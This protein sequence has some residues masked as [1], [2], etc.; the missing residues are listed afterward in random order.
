V[1]AGVFLYFFPGLTEKEITREWLRGSPIAEPMRDIWERNEGFRLRNITVVNNGPSGSGIIF[2]AVNDPE[3]SQ[4]PIGYYKDHQRWTD[5][6]SYWL[7]IDD[8]FPPTAVSLE[9]R[10]VVP[11]IDT[12]LAAG[13]V[14]CLPIIRQPDKDTRAANVCC[15]PSVQTSTAMKV[16]ERYRAI[17]QLTG[18]L[19]D[20]MYNAIPLTDSKSDGMRFVYESAAVLL[21]VNYRVGP[22]ETDVLECFEDE[23]VSAVIRAAIDADAVDIIQAEYNRGNTQ[24]PTDAPG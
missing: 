18:T 13:W 20:W 12:E 15:L 21:G 4:Q 6:G 8:R 5:C 3:Q 1:S 16:P 24:N 17:W 10:K 9:R 14:W 23:D 11:G 19:F 22:H 7:G 2:A